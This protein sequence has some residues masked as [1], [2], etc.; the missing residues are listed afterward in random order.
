MEI[1]NIISLVI[2]F[3][4]LCQSFTLEAAP[5]YKIRKLNS[6]KIKIGDRI[7]KVNMVFDSEDDII[8]SSDK[9]YMEVLDLS[10][11]RIG[12]FTANPIEKNKTKS[13][14]R[15]KTANV[16]LSVRQFGDENHVVADT[17]FYMLDT[18]QLAAGP[19]HNDNA[20]HEI[21]ITTD[22]RKFTRSIRKSEDKK[23]FVITREM[24]DGFDSGT[25]RVD[26][27]EKDENWKYFVY[28]N[29]HIELMPLHV[30]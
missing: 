9:E 2:S 4:F 29:L 16:H 27:L 25:V 7:A 12:S 23:Q 18:L 8:W 19:H 10:T 5:P 17:V 30:Y 6:E 15:L 22:N 24:F 28:R 26:I 11:L 20:T 3:F 13:F 1:K 21:V 14:F